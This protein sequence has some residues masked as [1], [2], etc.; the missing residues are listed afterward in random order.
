MIPGVYNV[1]TIKVKV[2]QTDVCV[3]VHGKLTSG[4]AGVTCEFEYD[5]SWDGLVKT[6]VFSAGCITKDVLNAE[7]E[8]E[9][10]WECLEYPGPYLKVGVYGANTDGTTVIPTIMA[11]VQRIVPGA[12]PGGDES[13]QQSPDVWAQLQAQIN[14]LK[15]GVPGGGGGSIIVDN[16]GYLTTTS[17]GFEIDADG[18]IVL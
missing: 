10:P 13:T 12:D 14:A 3:A 1:T 17:G 6:A 16:E 9:V 7:G 18:Y 4:M 11:D 5:K 2:M 8:V 15:D